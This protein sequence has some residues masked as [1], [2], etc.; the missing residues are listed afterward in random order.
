MHTFESLRRIRAFNLL[1]GRRTGCDTYGAGRESLTSRQEP[2][3]PDPEAKII[4]EY[5]IELCEIKLRTE[6]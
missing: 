5:E 2:E 6:E 3:P 1:M 4:E